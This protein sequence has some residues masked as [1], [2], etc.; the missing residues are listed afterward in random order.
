MRSG[1]GFFVLAQ[2]RRLAKLLG[3]TPDV[4][5][6]ASRTHEQCVEALVKVSKPTTRLDLRDAHGHDPSFGLSRFL[7]LYGDDV[8][9]LPPLEALRQGVGAEVELLIGTNAEEMNLYFVPTGVRRKIWRWLA[10]WLLGKSQPD[11]GKVLRT[12]GLAGRLSW[13][14]T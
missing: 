4:A 5:G 10:R 6:F 13:R 14:R 1:I 8:L 9:P 12:Y 2:L 3:V 11:A 7:P